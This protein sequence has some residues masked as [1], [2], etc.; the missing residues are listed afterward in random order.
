VIRPSTE[1]RQPG[2]IVEG[3]DDPNAIVYELRV[4]DYPE[5]FF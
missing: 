5:D 1:I 4:S 2:G 3:V